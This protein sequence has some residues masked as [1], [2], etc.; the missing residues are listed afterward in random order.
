MDSPHRN[1]TLITRQRLSDP[2]ELHLTHSKSSQTVPRARPISLLPAL[3]L[4]GGNFSDMMVPTS[5]MLMTRESSMSAPARTPKDKNVS[6]G[7]SQAR[8]AR[9]GL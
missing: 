8:A 6:S 3:A 4:D 7:N 1:G 2:E 9:N 5:R